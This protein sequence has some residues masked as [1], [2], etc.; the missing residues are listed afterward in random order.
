MPMKDIDS[1]IKWILKDK[2]LLREIFTGDKEEATKMSCLTDETITE[3]LENKLSGNR[4]DSFMAHLTRCDECLNIF[5][6]TYKVLNPETLSITDEIISRVKSYYKEMRRFVMV[7]K[8]FPDHI[9]PLILEPGFTRLQPSIPVNIR[10]QILGNKSNLIAVAK[11]IDPFWFELEVEKIKEGLCQIQIYAKY[12]QSKKPAKN[13]RI[14]L[15]HNQR[16]FDSYLTE[17][18][19]VVFDDVKKGRYLIKASEKG[20]HVCEFDLSLV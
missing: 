13:L 20:K 17:G 2:R 10:G 4:R 14:S 19:T 7:I 9:A 11:K 5:V 12:V 6:A 1:F 15:C 16:E 3:I 18:G 8:L